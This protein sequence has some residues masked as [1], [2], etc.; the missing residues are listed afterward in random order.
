MLCG[1]LRR[2]AC[3]FT[4]VSCNS[5][6]GSNGSW[7]TVPFD[8]PLPLSP[9]QDYIAAIDALSVYVK[10]AQFAWPR[11]GTGG[12][13]LVGLAATLGLAPGKAPLENWFPNA[14]YFVDGRGSRS[15][16]RQVGLYDRDTGSGALGD[17][18]EATAARRAGLST[19]QH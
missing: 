9:G 2:S 1:W 17:D 14:N 16:R 11:N 3:S 4:D 5:R 10:S 7:V 18:D 12:A 19:E 8:K 15:R 13:V 6:G